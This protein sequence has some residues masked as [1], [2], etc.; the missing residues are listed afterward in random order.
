MR[1]FYGHVLAADGTRRF[2]WMAED[3]RE[4]SP[5]CP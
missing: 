4:A 5:G 3:A 2:G 1:L